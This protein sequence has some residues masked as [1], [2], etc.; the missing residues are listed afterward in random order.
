[1][2]YGM[3]IPAHRVGGSKKLWGFRAYGLSESWAK[4]VPTVLSLAE[5]LKTFT[6]KIISV[7]SSP[8]IES[9]ASSETLLSQLFAHIFAVVKF[10]VNNI[11][12]V[13]FVVTTVFQYKPVV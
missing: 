2:G 6:K 4:R 3:Q 13:G 5:C 10:V 9:R 8:K 11:I 1:M 12:S 7:N